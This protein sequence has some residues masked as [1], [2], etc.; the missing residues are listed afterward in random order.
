MKYHIYY[1]ERIASFITAF[2][3]NTSSITQKWIENKFYSMDE[4]RM[5]YNRMKNY[6]EKARFTT[7]NQKQN[8]PHSQKGKIPNKKTMRCKYYYRSGYFDS[9]CPDKTHK[10][11]PSMPES[12]SKVTCLK[13]KKKRHLAFNC[14]PKYNC[15]RSSSSILE[16]IIQFETKSK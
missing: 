3:L 7:S 12:I 13:C 14:P 15:N 11:P 8:N 5:T 2:E 10:K 6:R 16:I 4:E 1:K 9:K